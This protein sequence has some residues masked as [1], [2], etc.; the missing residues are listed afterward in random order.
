M[1]TYK[2][3]KTIKEKHH[4][5]I[6]LIEENTC[7]VTYDDDAQKTSEVLKLT[8]KQTKLR[9]MLRFPIYK[10]DEYLTELIKAGF[11]VALCTELEKHKK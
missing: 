8:L 3:Y 10:I 6:I 2:T 7:F 11:R 1:A 9:K 5:R 4:D